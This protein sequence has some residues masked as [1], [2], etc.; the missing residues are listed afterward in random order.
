[1]AMPSRHR[2]TMCN[3]TDQSANF[4]FARS[5]SYTNI[6]NRTEGK[7]ASTLDEKGRNR[8]SFGSCRQPPQRP[9]AD[10][11][12]FVK[13]IFGSSDRAGVSAK[14]AG[15]SDFG[16]RNRCFLWGEPNTCSRSHP[17]IVG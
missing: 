6:S 15:G 1:M 13:D 4:A 10:G 2:Q 16:G 7:R 12:R 14:A 17:E 9:A 8:G 11:H 3:Q 5:N